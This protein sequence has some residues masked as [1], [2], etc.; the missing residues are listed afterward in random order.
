MLRFPHFP[1]YRLIDG[2]K[3]VSPTRRPLFTPRN[4][5]RIFMVIGRVKIVC[6]ERDIRINVSH[7]KGI[8]LDKSPVKDLNGKYS[9][10]SYE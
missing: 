1:D 10:G 2:G 5:P 8:H 7:K 9:R 3:V 4:I 6:N